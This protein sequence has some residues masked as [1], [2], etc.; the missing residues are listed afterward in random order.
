MANTVPNPMSQG[1]G[2]FTSFGIWLDPDNRR[3]H[4]QL[5][6]PYRLD[7]SYD[8]VEGQYE[9]LFWPGAGLVSTVNDMARFYIALDQNALVSQETKE[10]MFAPAVSTTGSDL[11][12]GLGWFTLTHKGVRLIWHYGWWPPCASAF[13]L[14]APDE[15]LT[16]IILAT[17]DNL[18]RPY[19]LGSGDFLPLDSAVG[20]AFYKT[21]VFE[22]RQGLSVPQ[23]DW[24]A[25]V[26][27]IVDPLSK[28]ADP[29][30]QEILEREL[31]SRRRLYDSV[32]R[33]DLSDRL[34]TV[35]RQVYAPSRLENY[36]ALQ[37]AGNP[38]AEFTAPLTM[39]YRVAIVCLVLM[40]LSAPVLWWMN[41]KRRKG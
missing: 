29:D 27:D 40:L 25:P 9:E 35:H 8:L 20:M 14:Q 5:A 38:P 16:F 21:F 15:N 12:H 36:S 34:R 6:R 33:L 26:E 19:Q 22:P 24:E 37:S 3:V 7:S 30:V 10:Q 41:R 4:R 17:T 1:E 23:V 2:F 11:P 32:G 13:V 31:L 39:Y 28:V 18:S